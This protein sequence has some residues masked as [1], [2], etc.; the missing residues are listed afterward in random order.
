MIPEIKLNP[1]YLFF[2]LLII[3]VIATTVK[4][5]GLVSEGFISYL[6]G[7]NNLTPQS[8]IA[9][10]NI[11]GRKI[12]KLYDDIY[13]DPMNGNSIFI[14]ASPYT[15]A[16][17]T[18]GASVQSIDVVPRTF[19]QAT[20]YSKIGEEILSQE[21]EESKKTMIESV[22][23]QWSAKDADS[24]NQLFY[25]T[26]GKDTYVYVIDLAGSSV[27][28]A[29]VPSVSVPPAAVPPASVP[30]ASSAGSE[31]M[32]TGVGT[33]SGSKPVESTVA[34]PLESAVA[35]TIGS[36]V[37]DSAVVDSASKVA[38]AIPGVKENMDGMTGSY[39]PAVCAYFLGNDI[40]SSHSFS[41]VDIINLIPAS[42]YSYQKSGKDDTNV[43]EIFYD[44]SKSVYQLLNNVW[45]DVTNGNIIVQSNK[46][47]KQLDVYY[48]G[49]K[50]S[51]ESYKIEA[52]GETKASKRTFSQ[53]TVK[54]Y[55]IQDAIDNHTI[56]Y[57]PNG[58]NTLITIFKNALESTNVLKPIKT[59]RFTRTGLY[60]S[61]PS[62]EPQKVD[63]TGDNK[64]V[65]DAFAR[66]YIYFNTNAVGSGN[67]DD[68][69]LKTQIVPPVCP[70][71]PGCKGVCTDCG[72]KGGSGTKTADASSL[73]FDSKTVVG[74]TGNLL[75]NTVGATGNVLNTTVD[76]AGNIV[77]KT[78]DTAGNVVNKT[79]DTAGNVVNKTVD[80]ATNVV[81][82]TFD[83]A[84]N[85]LGSTANKLGLDR[86]G[87]QQSY[88]GPTNTS[89]SANASGYPSSGYRNTEYR[90]GSNTTG[91]A[92]LPNSNPN[93]PYTYNGALQSKGANFM[94]VTADFSKFGR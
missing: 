9:Y 27:P 37:V 68:Y 69:L 18:T 59:R 30:P 79:V 40:H 53:S 74:K 56:M 94:A 55:F 60:G 5:W 70:A 32:N 29:S 1:L 82:K 45:Y 28:S 72:G 35:K 38:G 83:A 3:L 63:T 36:A 44:K 91:V 7:N 15:D 13:Y 14:K 33:T 75:S 66:W 25:V 22:E 80:T 89:T 58:D 77:G 57:W 65:L 24:T 4:R 41:D 43:I 71:C 93:D 16:A 23:T 46:T 90:P 47:N 10:S 50:F 34:K 85:L 17:D 8:V 12:F 51:D 87:Y 20:K 62:T 81:G 26:W 78:L 6:Y 67:S 88:G 31:V 52:D 92:S 61:E 21:C 73:A 64:E 84:G 19:N 76:T 39:K 11:S 54:P 2:I 86:I 49:N 48:R 42:S